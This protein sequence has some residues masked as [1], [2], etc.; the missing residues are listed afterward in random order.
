MLLKWIVI[1]LHHLF[2]LVSFRLLV[3]AGF[4]ELVLT[5]RKW[6]TSSR[7]V[8]ENGIVCKKSFELP[9]VTSHIMNSTPL[10]DVDGLPNPSGKFLV[11][12]G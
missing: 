1:I 6:G 7:T 12:F 3:A 9:H 5:R 2:Y 11:I 8:R 4:F 10:L